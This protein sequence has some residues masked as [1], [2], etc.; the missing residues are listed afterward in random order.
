MLDLDCK[1]L[2]KLERY[3]AGKI[4]GKERLGFETNLTNNSD[5][6]Q[7][8]SFFME[9]EAEKETFGRCLF[10]QELQKVDEEMNAAE[11]VI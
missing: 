1:L 9:F 10:K 5:L 8:L 6:A 11:M 7:T 2:D 4:S 3:V